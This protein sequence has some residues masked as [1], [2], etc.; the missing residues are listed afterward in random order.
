VGHQNHGFGSM[1]NGIFDCWDSSGNALSVCNLL[2]GI[3]GDVEIDLS[4]SWLILAFW[5]ILG[6]MEGLT[7]INTR[8]PLRSTSVIESLFERDMIA[9]DDYL[10]LF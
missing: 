6:T 3:E 2:I 10:G 1:I 5:L 9:I 8:L 7:L 4:H